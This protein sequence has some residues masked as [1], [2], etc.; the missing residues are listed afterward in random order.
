M[1][2]IP[3]FTKDHHSDRPAFLEGKARG[4]RSFPHFLGRRE[5]REG[6]KTTDESE[7][8]DAP[9]AN[10]AALAKEVEALERV[11]FRLAS[12]TDERM[13]AVVR[14]LLPQL[15]RLFPAALATPVQHQ[16]KDKVR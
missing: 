10:D 11:L 2:N 8:M 9:G 1:T 7:M 6:T 14:A 16:L 15:L 5:G 4:I 13:V 12:V 3:K